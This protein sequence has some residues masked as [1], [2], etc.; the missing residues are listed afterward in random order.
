M[1]N[2]SLSKQKKMRGKKK[3]KLHV[4]NHHLSSESENI[5]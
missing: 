5:E 3:N 2:D 4:I 1:I